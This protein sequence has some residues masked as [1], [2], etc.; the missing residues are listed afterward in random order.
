MFW[1]GLPTHPTWALADLTLAED[2]HDEAPIVKQ[3]TGCEQV[4]GI[5]EETRFVV[6]P[7]L[8]MCSSCPEEAIGMH[9]QVAPFILFCPCFKKQAV[10]AM[11]NQNA[12]LKH[13][14]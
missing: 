11:R 14:E 5:I 4:L 7:K 13:H 9:A 12:K 6:K 3:A 1:W 10:K 2:E 8:L